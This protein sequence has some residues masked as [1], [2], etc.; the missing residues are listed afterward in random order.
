MCQVFPKSTRN[1]N[2]NIGRRSTLIV[3]G[4]M[5]LADF[6][7][8]LKNK[9][10]HHH[11]DKHTTN[12]INNF[13]VW[14]TPREISN[15]LNHVRSVICAIRVYVIC[16]AITI[17]SMVHISPEMRRVA[18]PTCRC[19]FNQSTIKPATGLGKYF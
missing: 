6:T 7:P 18:L 11:K 1:N 19:L 15:L 4:L 17:F 16:Y 13:I 10:H 2:N 5:V 12:S 8:N 14:T 3:Y 9:T